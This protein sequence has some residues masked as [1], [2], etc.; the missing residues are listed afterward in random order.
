M[1]DRSEFENFITGDAGPVKWRPDP[2][3]IIV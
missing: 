3:N 2:L 1:S